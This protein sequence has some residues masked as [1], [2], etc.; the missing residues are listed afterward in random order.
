MKNNLYAGLTV[1]LALVMFSPVSAMA[2]SWGD[3]INDPTRFVVLAG[4]GGAAVLDQETGLIWEQSPDVT[5]QDWLPAQTFCNQKNV[6]GRRAWRLPAIQE[7]ASLVD[8]T[9]LPPGP[10]LPAGHPFTNVQ[11]VDNYHSATTS[12]SASG[13]DWAVF[14]NTGAVSTV[15]KL[16]A[17]F[18]W[19]V[20]GGQGV[21]PQ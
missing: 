5:T 10:T 14:F 12:G 11:V 3:Q 4:Y 21:N 8:T 2:D 6:A 19:C 16:S 13:F 9:V 17:R 1:I 20:R 15:G 18:V 7:L